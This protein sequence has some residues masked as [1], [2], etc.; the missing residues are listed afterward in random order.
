MTWVMNGMMDALLCSMAARSHCQI[1]ASLIFLGIFSWYSLYIKN[2]HF[3]YLWD[4]AK[5]CQLFKIIEKWI[6]FIFLFFSL[7][8]VI[9]K[10]LYYVKTF[11][12]SVNNILLVLD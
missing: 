2:S 3:E 8:L 10:T 6:C 12:E 4:Q 7:L 5:V 11:L 1:A 9:L